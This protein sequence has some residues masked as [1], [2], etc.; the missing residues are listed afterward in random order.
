MVLVSLC[1]TVH[2]LENA[3]SAIEL[4][5]YSPMYGQLKRNVQMKKNETFLLLTPLCKV[6]RIAGFTYLI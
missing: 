5:M 6:H 1:D 4:S 2:G 3:S